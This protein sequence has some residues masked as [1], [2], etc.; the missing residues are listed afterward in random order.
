LNSGFFAYV[1][2][3]GEIESKTALFCP[4]ISFWGVFFPYFCCRCFKYINYFTSIIKTTMLRKLA[5][6][7]SLLMVVALVSCGGKKDEEAEEEG[8]DAEETTVTKTAVDMANGAV[9]NGTIT[10]DG[11]APAAKAIKMDADPVCKSAH[12]TPQMDDFWV[13]D[14]NG[15]VANAF[16]YVKD[17][18]GGKEFEPLA[19]EVTLDQRGCVY[20]PRVAGVTVGAS[21]KFTNSDQT[22]HNIHSFAEKNGQ[23]NEGQPAGA[24]PAVKKDEF[25]KPEIMIPVKCDVHGWMKSYVGVLSHPFFAVTGPDG[26]FEIKGL[27]AGEYT[28]A[29]WH[30]SSKGTPAGVTSEMKITVAAKETKTADMKVKPE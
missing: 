10:I 17:G 14:A 3:N 11:A 28:L 2:K 26:K 22:L 9:I 24:A 16:V 25:S 1:L 23:F 20:I 18:L 4:K 30:E 6:L 13:V 19:Q 12:S 7:L 15:G 8:E 29:V 5:Y 21:V 27:P